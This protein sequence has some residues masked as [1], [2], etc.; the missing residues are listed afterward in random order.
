M[1]MTFAL[2]LFNRTFNSSGNRERHREGP[3][4]MEGEHC[5]RSVSYA[6]PGAVVWTSL[7]QVSSEQ[8]CGCC[9]P[10]PE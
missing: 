3:C 10:S 7:V 1:N 8:V 2:S 4:P 6:Y 5:P 9:P